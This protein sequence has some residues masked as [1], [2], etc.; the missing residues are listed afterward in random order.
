MEGTYVYLW[1]IH[2]DVWQKP[3][4]YCKV[5]AIILQLKYINKI[6]T[7]IF[8]IHSTNPDRMFTTCKA[9]NWGFPGGSDGKESA[10]NAGDTGSIPNSR[11]SPGKRA[12]LPTPVF[13]PGESHGQ[14]SL[15]GH[16]PWGHKESDRTERLTLSQFH[17]A[18]TR[19]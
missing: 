18:K 2:A 14:R 10:C 17:L 4:Q 13:L 8:I 3:S 11:R 9:Q 15:M 7:R 19:Y 12:W 6:F 1:P 16:S 5:R